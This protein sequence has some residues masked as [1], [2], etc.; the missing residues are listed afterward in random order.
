MEDLNRS[1]LENMTANE[2]ESSFKKMMDNETEWN[3]IK[4]GY[5][6]YFSDTNFT[7][8]YMRTII[9]LGAPLNVNGTR[10]MN[11]SHLP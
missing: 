6:K 11:K 5:D 8:N 1:S 9:I 3:K 10:Y 2:F 4:G 7:V